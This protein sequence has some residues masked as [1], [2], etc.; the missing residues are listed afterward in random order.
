MCSPMP[1]QL[2]ETFESRFGLRRIEMWGMTE[3]GCVTWTDLDDP[4]PIGSAGKTLV[5]FYELQIADPDTDE[6]LPAGQVGEILV[7]SRHPFTMMQGYLAMPEETRI[8][9]RNLWFHTGDAGYL[10]SEGNLYFVERLKD[11]I[12]S[13]SENISAYDI[14]RAGAVDRRYC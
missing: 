8:S 4:H 5:D 13:R 6:P 14:E 10:D 2:T 11:R 1:K 9:W 3:T 7:R 12:R